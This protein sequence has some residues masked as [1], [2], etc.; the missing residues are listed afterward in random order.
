MKYLSIFLLIFI[1]ISC[2]EHKPS[3][4]ENQNEKTTLGDAITSSKQV[5]LKHRIQFINQVQ[6][7]ISNPDALISILKE[8][9]SNYQ[10]SDFYN[11]HFEMGVAEIFRSNV[12]LDFDQ[13]QLSFLL[14][15]FDE[16]DSA[17]LNLKNIQTIVKILKV[18]YPENY[19][20]SKSLALRIVKKNKLMIESMEWDNSDIKAQK[21][22]EVNQIELNLNYYR[23]QIYQNI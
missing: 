13:E 14:S 21:I 20:D 9:K 2:S 4:E 17:L 23:A 8:L 7:N 5:D 16:V 12:Y 18:K 22:K 15:E 10:S 3:I 1:T 6:T 11:N 19:D